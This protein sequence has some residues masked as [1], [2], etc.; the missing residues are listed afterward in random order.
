MRIPYLCASKTNFLHI[1]VFCHGFTSLL[2]FSKSTPH[3]FC[4]SFWLICKSFILITLQR[5]FNFAPEVSSLLIYCIKP[6]SVPDLSTTITRGLGPC[7]PLLFIWSGSTPGHGAYH[8]LSLEI[9]YVAP[10][11][12]FDGWFAVPMDAIWV[13][14]LSL[15]YRFPHLFVIRKVE[16]NTVGEPHRQKA[17][18]GRGGKKFT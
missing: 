9:E 2:R 12:L 17:R 11:P 16:Y 13:L 4:P 18:T 5:A 10:R 8:L 1:S 6:T 3:R 15:V 7:T 14:Y